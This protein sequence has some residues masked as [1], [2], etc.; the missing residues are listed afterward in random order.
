LLEYYVQIHRDWGWDEST[1]NE[2]R[3]AANA[4]SAVIGDRALGKL[5]VLGAGACRLT[6]ELHHRHTADATLALDIDPLPFIVANKLL[7]GEPVSLY[8]FPPWPVDGASLF[9][10]RTLSNR[11]ENHE[12][13]VHLAFADAVDPPILPE[14]FDSVLTPWFLDQVPEALPRWLETIRSFLR[15]GGRFINHG[16]LLFQHERTALPH[17][18]LVDE[19]LELVENAGFRV[20]R[21]DFRRFSYLASPIGCQGRIETVLTFSAEKL[22]EAPARTREATEPWLTNDGTPVPRWAGL[23]GYRPEHPMFEAIV[24]LVDGART[25]GDIARELVNRHG[26]PPDAALPA[27]RSALRAIARKLGD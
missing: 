4:V 3:E 11:R 17:R 16:P 12:G 20:E 9:A 24:G 7:R 15:V 10:D 27:V 14:S 21:H 22:A 5:L 26:L 2:A 6:E 23:D 13:R 1:P 25:A 19:V 18:Y 8:E